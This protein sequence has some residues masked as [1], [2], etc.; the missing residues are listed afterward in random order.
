MV[1]DLNDDFRDKDW[2]HISI[3]TQ[4]FTSNVLLTSNVWLQAITSVVFI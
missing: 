4:K 1:T 3:L 2:K